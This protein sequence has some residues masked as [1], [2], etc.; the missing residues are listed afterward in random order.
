MKARYLFNGISGPDRANR[1]LG[2][3]LADRFER[4]PGDMVY[5]YAVMNTLAFD[6]SIRFETNGYYWRKDGFSDREAATCNESCDAFVCPLADM[7]SPDW[8]WYVRHLTDFVK[9]LKVPVLVPCVGV[10]GDWTPGGGDDR[11]SQDVK[12]FVSAVLDRS[13]CIG[14]RGESTARILERLGFSRERHFRVLGCPTLY[15]YGGDLPP[16]KPIEEDGRC[17]FSLNIRAPIESAR[18]ISEMAARF[19]SY[20]MVSQDFREFYRFML[21]NGK[22]SPRPFEEK[23]EYRDL[24]KRLAEENRLRFFLNRKPWETF[25]RDAGFS[26]GHRIHGA[27]LS[28]LAGTP[29]AVVPFE[30]RT[31][32]LAEFHGL[33]MLQPRPFR[34]ESEW[35]D[36]LAGLDYSGISRRQRENFDAYLAFFRDNGIATV[37]DKGTPERTAF[38]LERRIPQCF[39]DDSIPAWRHHSVADRAKCVATRYAVQARNKLRRAEPARKT[40]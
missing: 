40:D 18:F 37:F 25:L 10:R 27:L 11:I 17:V 6:A 9:R 30:S 14:V 22:W 19:R 21:T 1:L 28:I 7:F 33:P 31:R 4:N 24:L 12:A 15:T 36:A 34:G 8:I 32:E 39:P 2:G 3:L 20:C 38:P 29:A 13:A 16:L 5:A 26:I 23:P 35:R